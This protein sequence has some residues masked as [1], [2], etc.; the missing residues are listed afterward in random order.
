MHEKL[1]VQTNPLYNQSEN[2]VQL[3]LKQ[4]KPKEK[5]TTKVWKK[6]LEVSDP[7]IYLWRYVSSI[8]IHTIFT[9]ATQT[10]VANIDFSS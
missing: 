10:G 7:I 3:K 6:S 1:R 4:S 2:Y 9:D 5:Q 8:S